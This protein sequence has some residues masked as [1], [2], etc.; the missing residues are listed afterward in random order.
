VL[1]ASSEFT[2]VETGPEAQDKRACVDGLQF[3]KE[4]YA[5]FP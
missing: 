5:L 3:E 4:P 2:A 1:A